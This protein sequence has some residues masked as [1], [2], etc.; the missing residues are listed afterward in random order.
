[1]N[2][3]IRRSSYHNVVRVNEIQKYID[4][5]CVQTF[6]IKSAKIV[7]LNERPKPKPG[8]GVTNTCEICCKSL[9]GSFRFCFLGCKLGG[10]KR[11]DPELTFTLRMK[12]KNPFHGSGSELDDE[13]S[14]PRKIKKTPMF[15]RLIKGLSIYPSSD[16]GDHKATGV[17]C[18]LAKVTV[19]AADR[20]V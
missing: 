19:K 6:I 17:W 18:C 11:G 10:M 9:L 13:S 4:I 2:M 3:Q 20:R 8:K 16:Y 1:M 12:H 14:T 5:S 7:F 15:N